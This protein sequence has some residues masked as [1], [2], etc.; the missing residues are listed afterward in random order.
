MALW[1]LVITVFFV[2]LLGGALGGYTNHLI[3]T[4]TKLGSAGLWQSIVIGTTASFMVPLFLTMTSSKLIESIF[5]DGK[6]P[7]VISNLLILT[8]FSLLA[9][10]SS[11]A[12]ITNLSERLFQRIV[13]SEEKI[14]KVEAEVLD[15]SREPEGQEKTATTLAIGQP[16]LTEAEKNLLQALA[17]GRYTYRTANGLEHELKTVDAHRVLDDLE[18]KGC[19]KQMYLPHSKSGKNILY[20]RITKEGLDAITIPG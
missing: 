13:K 12:F 2:L 6:M 8:G 14:D 9:S 19:V 15:I 5:E 10:V 11:R 18:K 1:I 16:L 20:W 7:M 17:Y 3:G 4:S